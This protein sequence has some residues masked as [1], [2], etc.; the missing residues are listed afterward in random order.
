MFRALGVNSRADGDE[1]N[2]EEPSKANHVVSDADRR[3]NLPHITTMNVCI[4]MACN[5]D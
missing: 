2:Y 4:A 1:E 3:P 5:I